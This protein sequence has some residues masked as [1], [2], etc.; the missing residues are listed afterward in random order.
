M[1]AGDFD[2]EKLLYPNGG[3]RHKTYG[4]LSTE[5]G[6]TTR[7]TLIDLPGCTAQG[8]TF[9]LALRAATMAVEQWLRQARAAG[10]PI[11][12]PRE[13]DEYSADPEIKRARNK[14]AFL[15][16]VTVDPDSLS[17]NAQRLPPDR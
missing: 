4:C 11:P 15:W 13:I 16:Y 8:R 14:G 3:P 6:G 7:I 5:D 17:E 12:E 1:N 9:N 2:E 10:R